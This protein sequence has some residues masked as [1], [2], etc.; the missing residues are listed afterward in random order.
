MKKTEN[1]AVAEAPVEKT[2]KAEAPRFTK[3][4]LLKSKRFEPFRDVM[5]AIL[6]EDQEYTIE[7]TEKAIETW[8]K[9]K[10]N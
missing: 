1:E 10:V 6:E 3:A 7:E 5:T 9:G 8:M 4:A 2:A